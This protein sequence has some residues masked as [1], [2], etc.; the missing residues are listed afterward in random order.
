MAVPPRFSFCSSDGQGFCYVLFWLPPKLFAFTSSL[1]GFCYV[2][3]HTGRASKLVHPD[4][5]HLVVREQGNR[6]DLQVC[7]VQVAVEGKKCLVI[8]RTGG[9]HKTPRLANQNGRG[10]R[11]SQTRSGLA[12]TKRAR[13]A[14]LPGSTCPDIETRR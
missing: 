7:K 8:R 2:G 10:A 6:I 11:S 4:P 13:V 9:K 14:L 12:L 5:R 3:C 1:P